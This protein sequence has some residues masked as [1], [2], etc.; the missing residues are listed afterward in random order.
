MAT[1]KLAGKVAVVTGASKWIGAAIAKQRALMHFEEF[2][3][4]QDSSFC[5]FSLRPPLPRRK[6]FAKKSLRLSDSR[7]P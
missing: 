3:K 2:Q 6:C 4:S 1:K 5:R 7:K